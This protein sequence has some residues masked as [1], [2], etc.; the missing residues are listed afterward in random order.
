M[1]KMILILVCVLVIS[2]G[3]RAQN[4][5]ETLESDKILSELF[6][7]PLGIDNAIGEKDFNSLT[8]KIAKLGLEYKTINLG[9]YGNAVSIKP[10][11]MRI[12]G[13]DIDNLMIL[14][15]DNINGIIYQSKPC[16]NY[17]DMFDFLND[18]LMSQSQLSKESINDGTLKVYM[19]TPDCGIAAGAFDQN[20]IAMTMLIDIRNLFGFLRLPILSESGISTQT[21]S[22]E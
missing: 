16:D 7:C 18:V 2:V 6:V 4:L 10:N 9:Q 14:V 17:N 21:C 11:G 19:L 3:L 13:V 12:G 22:D 8:D 5:M 15:Q 1:K 20:K